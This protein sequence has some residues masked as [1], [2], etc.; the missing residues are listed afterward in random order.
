M[1]QISHTFHPCGYITTREQKIC[2]KYNLIRACKKHLGCSADSNN[3]CRYCS[4]AQKAANED[5]KMVP[6][7]EGWRRAGLSM[8]EEKDESEEYMLWLKYQ[9]NVIQQFRLGVV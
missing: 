1:Y 2:W 9:S 8:I 3:D 7:K 6:M 4:Q 5:S